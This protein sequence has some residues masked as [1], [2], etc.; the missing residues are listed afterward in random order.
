MKQ[1]KDSALHLV[2]IVGAV[3]QIPAPS[4]QLLPSEV[5]IFYLNQQLYLS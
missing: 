2:T 4:E 1:L 5:P 3:V